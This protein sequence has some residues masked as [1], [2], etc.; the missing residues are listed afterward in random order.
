[1]SFHVMT[2]G[3]IPGGKKKAELRDRLNRL[4]A[5]L[6]SENTS[7]IY[8]EDRVKSIIQDVALVFGLTEEQILGRQRW[9]PLATARQVAMMIALESQPFG[10]M[11]QVS[12]HFF[13]HRTTMIY[14]RKT[15]LA[16]MTYDQNL[17]SVVDILRKKYVK[18]LDEHL[19]NV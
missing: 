1:M 7:T 5:F 10:R 4:T 18:G 8:F 15:I 11:K 13:K 17:A 9:Q 6:H 3:R 12:S 14:S 2:L 16:I 19:K